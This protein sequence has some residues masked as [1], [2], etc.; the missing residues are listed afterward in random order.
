MIDPLDGTT[1]FIHA[2]PYFCISVALEKKLTDGRWHPV[3]GMVYDP[4]RDEEFYGEEY[5]GA[6]LA[7]R[8]LQVSVRHTLD[9]ASLVTHSPKHDGQHFTK[10]MRCFTAVS[11]QSKGARIMGATALDLAYIAS[12][13]FDG[14]WYTSFKRWD[15]SAG[16]LLLREA[17]ATLTQLDGDDNLGNPQTLLAA[18]PRLHTTLGKLLTP[19]WKQ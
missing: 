8:R 2:V 4:L 11:E 3:A 17:G 1:N 13:R 7:N 16:I 12:G 19:I 15:V 10:A 9:E 5:K 18:T 6:F 14:G